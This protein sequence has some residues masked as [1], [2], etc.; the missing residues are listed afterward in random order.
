MDSIE[1]MFQ[2]LLSVIL[3][4]VITIVIYEYT[5]DLLG[6]RFSIQPHLSISLSYPI[7]LTVDILL[8]HHVSHSP[9]SCDSLLSSLIT[10]ILHV[11]VLAIRLGG[12]ERG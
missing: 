7:D 9:P 3:E 10:R 1:I 12:I 2:I 4:C 11:V 6:S 8:L 5:V